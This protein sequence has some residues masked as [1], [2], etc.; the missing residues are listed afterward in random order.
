MKAKETFLVFAG[1]VAGAVAIQL[2]PALVYTPS[3]QAAAASVGTTGMVVT[4]DQT[5]SGAARGAIVVQ[6]TANRKV[7]VVSYY[8]SI[9]GTFPNSTTNL[10]FLSA[11]QSFTY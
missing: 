3:A 6:D 2:L 1:A 10:L 9:S 5:A 11:N 8:H 7:T 4:E